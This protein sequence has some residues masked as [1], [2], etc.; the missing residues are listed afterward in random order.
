MKI[1]K[2]LYI[3]PL[4]CLFSCNQTNVD[5]NVIPSGGTKMTYQEGSKKLNDTLTNLTKIDALGVS[6]KDANFYL[7]SDI[8]VND[9]SSTSIVCEIQDLDFDAKV[10]GLT[11][12]T[13]LNGIKASLE[14]HVKGSVSQD[15]TKKLSV[16][17]SAKAYVTQ[18][19]LYLDLSDKGIKNLSNAGIIT[20]LP[21]DKFYGSIVSDA[22]YPIIDTEYTADFS[23]LFEALDQINQNYSDFITYKSYNNYYGFM[24]EI[25]KDNMKKVLKD[26]IDQIPVEGEMNS[27]EVAS[28]KDFYKSTIDSLLEE[29]KFNYIKFGMTFDSNCITSVSYDIDAGSVSNMAIPDEN[30]N[31]I[32]AKEV[33]YIKSKAKMTIDYNDNVKINFPSFADYIDAEKVEPETI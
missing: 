11:T 27:S 17:A 10:S 32:M 12:A 15:D 8:F 22:Q 9:V 1:K 19:K 20:P 5:N 13:D 4:A 31:V 25:N 6:I 26:Y 23:Q 28:Y 21:Y 29:S 18:S 33:D 30:G 24:I 2:I 14:G 16:D 3:L 7:K